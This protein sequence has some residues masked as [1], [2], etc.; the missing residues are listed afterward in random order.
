MMLHIGKG[1]LAHAEGMTRLCAD[2]TI[3]QHR[4]TIWFAVESAQEAEKGGNQ[5]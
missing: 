2:I 3:G 1:R 4:T 5:Q